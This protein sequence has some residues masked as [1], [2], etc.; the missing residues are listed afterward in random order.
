[1]QVGRKGI[2]ATPPPPHTHI[3]DLGAGAPSPPPGSYAYD[4]SLRP[5]RHPYIPVRRLKVLHVSALSP[6]SNVIPTDS[7]TP[8][9][10]GAMQSA[11]KFTHTF[12]N[13]Y[14]RAE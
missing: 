9:H 5:L 2:P 1:M 7:C 14:T 4:S 11:G 12:H 3:F 8:L 6:F 10:A 13:M